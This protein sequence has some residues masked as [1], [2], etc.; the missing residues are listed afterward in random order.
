LGAVRTP[1][2]LLLIAAA[3]LAG[4]G[5]SAKTT[6]QT[7][8][9]PVATTT[10]ATTTAPKAP[11]AEKASADNAKKLVAVWKGKPASAGDSDVLSLQHYLTSLSNKCSQDVPT[12]AGSIDSGVKTLKKSGINESPVAIAATLDKEVPGKGLAP[13]CQGVLAAVLVAIEKR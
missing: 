4:C 2:G 10:A 11:E 9:T 6:T 1:L 5:S 12:L 3:L 8:S 7:G 13:D